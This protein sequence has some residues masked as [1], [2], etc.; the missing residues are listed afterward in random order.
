VGHFLYWLQE[1]RARIFVVATANDIGRLPPELFRRG[2]FDEIFFVDLPAPEERQEIIDLYARRYLR[3]SLSGT[4]LLESLITLSEDFAGSDLEAAVADVAKEELL[5][6]AAAI[7]DDFWYK[8]FRNTVPLSKTNPEAI[9]AIRAW[10]KD[11]AVPASGIKHQ[12]AEVGQQK[13]RRH[14]LI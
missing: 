9:E 14:V 13:P 7:N 11:R 12:E 6:G 5:K 8:V 3:R 4:P 2:R 1:S 10:G